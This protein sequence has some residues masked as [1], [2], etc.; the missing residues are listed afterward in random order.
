M[1]ITTVLLQKSIDLLNEITDSPVEPY[2]VVDGQTAAQ[3][4][5]YH[6]D[7]AYGGYSL[8]RMCEGG[9]SRDV[10][11]CGYVTKRSLYDQIY[12]YRLGLEEGKNQ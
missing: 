8:R 2:K 1:R 9:G 10:F 12:A 11:R 5:N 7:S 3:T 4:G 6:L